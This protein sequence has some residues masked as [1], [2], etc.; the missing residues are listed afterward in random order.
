MLNTQT[1]N[2]SNEYFQKILERCIYYIMS[3]VQCS[4]VETPK[5]THISASPMFFNMKHFAPSVH[6]LST[7]HCKI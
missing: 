5:M 7:Q 2:R 3:T 4:I 6:F 1:Q